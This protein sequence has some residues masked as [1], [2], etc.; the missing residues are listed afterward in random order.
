M[1]N[2]IAFLFQVNDIFMTKTNSLY[3]NRRMK[4]DL[5]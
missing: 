5:L 1:I 4:C 2:F 3:I